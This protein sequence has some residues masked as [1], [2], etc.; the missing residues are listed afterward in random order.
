MH[1]LN[2]QEQEDDAIVPA[3]QG[4]SVDNEVQTQPQNAVYV[5]YPRLWQAVSPWAM[6]NKDVIHIAY[7]LY[8]RNL[9]APH[10]HDNEAWEA[11]RMK[12]NFCNSAR[13][14]P[15][16]YVE[17]M[18]RSRLE[19]LYTTDVFG[20]NYFTVRWK[21]KDSMPDNLRDECV[22]CNAADGCNYP[23][24]PYWLCHIIQKTA[25]TN[26]MDPEAIFDALLGQ[27]KI[28]FPGTTAHYLDTQIPPEL[29]AGIDAKSAHGAFMLLAS[30]LIRPGEQTGFDMSYTHIPLC[31]GDDKTNKLATMVNFWKTGSGN[32]DTIAVNDLPSILTKKDDGCRKCDF[33]QCPHRLAAY[34]IN[35][36]RRFNVPVMDLAYH[37]AQNNTYA[38]ISVMDNYQF[39]HFLDAVQ[40]MPMPAASKEEIIKIVHYIVGRNQNR[41]IPFLP[42]N[43]AISSPDRDKAF[44]LAEILNNALWHFD[45]F[46]CGKDNTKINSI[47]MSTQ[48]VQNLI[49]SYTN[50]AAGSVFNLYDVRLLCNNKE[51]DAVY[52]KLL[53]IMEDKKKEIITILIGEKEEIA[54]F[55]QCYPEFK[56]KIFTKKLE[57]HD[58]TSHTAYEELVDKLT[59][60]FTIPEDVNI[61]LEQYVQI[62]YP[63]SALRNK[64]F[65]NDLYEKIL[66]NHF[67]HDVQADTVLT[68]NDIPYITPPRSEEEVFA[69]I[70]QLTGLQT[71]KSELKAINDLVKFNLKMGSANSNAVNMHMV[72]TGNPGTGKTTVARL[73]AEI[74]HSIG[75]IQE[76]KLVVCS[77]KDL[78]GEYLG[79]TAPRTAKKCEE[80]YNGV[81]FIDEAYQLNPYNSDMGDPFKE[82]CIAELIQQMENNRNRLVVIFAG[83]T[84]EMT[85]FLDRA[86]TGLRSRI[87]KVIEFPDYTVDE[88][89]D[90]FVKIVK[91]NGMQLDSDAHNKA[92]YIFSHALSDAKRFGNARY[93]R[94]LYERSLL[95]HAANTSHMD[96]NDPN[97]RILTGDELTAPH[98]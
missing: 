2:L 53:K 60:T 14:K 3:A 55:F 9:V 82:E 38:H 64:E 79:T 36:S 4:Q 88:L 90:I 70:N 33:Q 17:T 71:V 66:F 62:A 16:V 39:T 74:L 32:Y 65:V 13:L 43:T 69:E 23:V 92:A 45:Y 97:L 47:Y 57:M 18:N 73:T 77:A 78:I 26:N 29:L 6:E 37:V 41:N 58:I 59:E 7:Y 42:F 8:R 52:H 76:N 51:F 24:C 80:A 54:T 84:Q 95:N 21:R 27:E 61:R 40:N 5:D 31:R 22:R 63:A 94:N 20:G 48:S 96:K 85:D 50:A 67:N 81:L 86:N 34:F 44:E 56:S 91:K 15:I 19:Q 25:A 10:E 72:F 11:I 93:A 87:G 68:L 83:Y 98:N 49:E 1:N 28:S 89:L 30:N 75:F 12:V 46:W 35:L